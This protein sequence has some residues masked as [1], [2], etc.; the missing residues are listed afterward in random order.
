MEK[1]NGKVWV[2]FVINVLVALWGISDMAADGGTVAAV[3]ITVMVGCLLLTGAGI[4]MLVRGDPA[5][6][7]LGA[8]GS[9]IFVPIVLICLIGCLQCPDK[10]RNLALATSAGPRPEV[11]AVPGQAPQCRVY[12]DRRA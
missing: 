11:P 6:G 10:L 4:A 5:G 8:V 1:L 9:A 12:G 2:G 3:F 7:I